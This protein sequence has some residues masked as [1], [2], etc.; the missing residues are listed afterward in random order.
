MS[1]ADFA[2]PPQPRLRTVSQQLRG[3][4]DGAGPAHGDDDS[5]ALAWGDWGSTGYSPDRTAGAQQ[6]YQ[7]PYADLMSE[8]A[9]DPNLPYS[10]R[11]AS[12][13]AVPTFDATMHLAGGDDEP[14]Q[15]QLDSNHFRPPP[16]GSHP[17]PP[18]HQPLPP[19]QLPQSHPASPNRSRA[20]S[21]QSSNAP[22][23]LHMSV[24]TSPSSPF[25]PGPLP[26]PFHDHRASF[27]SSTMN[28]SHSVRSSS[29]SDSS[30]VSNLNMSRLDSS[31]AT[32][33]IYGGE[34]GSTAPSTPYRS[35]SISRQNSQRGSSQ[36]HA[37]RRSS[38]IKTS[39]R[40]SRKLSN[41]ERKAICEFSRTHPGWKQDDIGAHFGYERSTISKTLK[42]KDRYLAMDSADEA[43]ASA[44]Q[45]FLHTGPYQQQQQQQGDDR[46]S[47]EAPSPAAT[48][49]PS[50]ST[51][52][53]SFGLVA[54]SSTSS[55]VSLGSTATADLGASTSSNL[56][57]RVLSGGRFPH[58]DNALVAWAE[59]HV[60]KGNSLADSVLQRQARSIAR[61]LPGN[62]SFKASQSWLDGFKTRAGIVRGAFVHDRAPSPM[63]PA[64]SNAQRSLDPPREEDDE[65]DDTSAD[66]PVRRSKRS[67]GSKTVR[68]LASAKSTLAAFAEGFGGRSS[69][70]AAAS[71]SRMDAELASG[72]FGDLSMDSEA[73][74]THSTAHSRASTQGAERPPQGA[75]RPP[76]LAQPFSYSPGGDGQGAGTPSRMSHYAGQE[77]TLALGSSLG[78]GSDYSPPDGMNAHGN[79]GMY[80]GGGV[81]AGGLT[82][83]YSPSPHAL[84]ASYSSAQG[85]SASS[86]RSSLGT[87]PQQQ[88]MY[89]TAS[90]V[91]SNQHRRSGSTA[92]STSVYSGLTAFSSQNGPGTPLSGSMYG[93]FRDSQGNL[94]ASVPGTPANPA[95]ASSTSSAAQLGSYFGSEQAQLQNS[96]LSASASGA[97]TT[98]TSQYSALASSSSSSLASASQP[99]QQQQQQ[100]RYP[101]HSPAYPQASFDTQQQQQASATVATAAANRRATISGGLPFN[102]AARNSVPSSAAMT[103]SSSFGAG[104]R[105]SMSG[106]SGAPVTLEQAFSSLEIALEYL[107]TRAGQDYVSPKDLVVL[108]DLRGKMERARN[109]QGVN[110]AAIS[111]APATPSGLGPSGGGPSFHAPF[112]PSQV[113]A[114]F[115]AAA[116]ANNMVGPA[117]QQR[118]RL[119]RTQST[120]S[121]PFFGGGGPGG[122]PGRR[123]GSSLSLYEVDGH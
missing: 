106:A 109:A 93:S 123:P 1:L 99:F 34:S 65:E 28:P 23:P 38:P 95:L 66:A 112:M 80:G 77:D 7:D 98:P 78:A 40:H 24:L 111:S 35:G 79:A 20:S 76:Q 10:P 86:S 6:P 8:N 29:P 122:V 84:G 26:S 121:V 52:Q 33:S 89:G 119:S 82:Q 3:L 47:S 43:G 68:R 60:A 5:G 90:P 117:K 81:Y 113:N 11:Q 19:A 9:F 25:F 2:F 101:Q 27:S 73:T 88:G 53:P 44:V 104:S 45:A 92:S 69:S 115:A 56:S 58:I 50:S 48:D 54:S 59:S 37:R 18:H 41:A 70:P 46:D 16:D 107:S 32:S 12:G 57:S 110:L 74:P 17:P 116:A 55:L 97:G 36:M 51:P 61:D 62:E 49:I 114:S 75:E 4:S 71:S 72:S 100:Q 67:L 94:C 30:S 13:H 21:L 85:V 87:F 15:Y 103:P 105:T 102:S 96:F 14:A 91:P 64:L 22:T 42:H 120:S 31:S 39:G 63:A 108:A 118:M 83:P